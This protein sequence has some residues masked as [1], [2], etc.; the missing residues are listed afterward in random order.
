MI[1]RGVF[2]GPGAKA[3]P[4]FLQAVACPLRRRSNEVL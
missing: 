3:K 1:Q 4:N 2:Q